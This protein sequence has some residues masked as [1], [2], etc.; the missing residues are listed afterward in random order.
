MI[1]SCTPGW[2]RKGSA[3]RPSWRC[4]ATRTWTRSILTNGGALMPSGRPGGSLTTQASQTRRWVR[5][6]QTAPS[7]STECVALQGAPSMR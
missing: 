2:R 1:V 6:D 5:A 3:M 7:W 4:S